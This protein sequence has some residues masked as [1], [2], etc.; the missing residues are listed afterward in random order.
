MFSTIH[1]GITG[2]GFD[3]PEAQQSMLDLFQACDGGSTY[4]AP[5]DR[6]RK[7]LRD[8]MQAELAYFNDVLLG[9]PIDEDKAILFGGKAARAAVSVA[10]A[11]LTSKRTEERVTL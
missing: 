7:Y 1:Y 4:G 11:V 10:S 5:T 6:M 9:K 8:A 3:D 2:C